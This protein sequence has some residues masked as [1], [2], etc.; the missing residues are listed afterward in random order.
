[1]LFTF[2]IQ[3]AGITKP[4]VWRKLVV[5]DNFTFE[6]FHHIIQ[7]AFGWDGYHLYQFSEKGYTSDWFIGEPSPEDEDEVR[8]S[9]KIKLSQ[10]FGKKGQKFIYVYDFGDNWEHV[11]T[12]EMIAEGTAKYADCI[13]GKGKCPPEDCGGVGGY[14]DLKVI[15]ADPENAEHDSMLEW[16]G[17][18]EDDVFDPAFFDLE[19]T[20]KLVK[21]I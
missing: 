5:P 1:M 21:K 16:L 17:M 4:P 13:D 11:I 8:D 20:R 14:E 10:V 6:H 12:L 15:L 2:R 19:V 3:I 9:R 7:V 18:E